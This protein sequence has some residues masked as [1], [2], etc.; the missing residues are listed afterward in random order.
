V[1]R[2]AVGPGVVLPVGVY[3]WNGMTATLR[4]YNG[5][6]LSGSVALTVGEFYDGDKRTLN[7][8]ADLRPGR[9]LS[10]N[11]TYQINDADL[12]PGSFVTHLTGLRANLSFSTDLLASAYVQY[13]S[14]GQLAASQ[15]RFNY[16][17]RTID[18]LYVVFNENR[19]ME[20]PF[21]GRSN[22]SLVMKIT[23]SLHR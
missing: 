4:T 1:R 18:N 23:Y 9:T 12:G 7:V 14:A 16:I 5:R 8:Q 11:P 13:N 15:I 2:F 3:D 19:Y 10:F 20:G 17:F 22:R 6:P 21:R